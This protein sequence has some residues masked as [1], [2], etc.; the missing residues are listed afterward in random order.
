VL[1]AQHFRPLLHL[2]SLHKNE[3]LPQ[4]KDNHT[5]IIARCYINIYVCSSPLPSMTMFVPSFCLTSHVVSV[6][7][8]IQQLG[9]RC[10][11]VSNR[12]ASHCFRHFRITALIPDVSSPP[13]FS[14]RV[15]SVIHYPIASYSGRSRIALNGTE[16]N[17]FFGCWDITK[18]S[19]A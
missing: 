9:V 14:S 1:V 8:L 15:R 3:C 16:S 5:C 17:R 18:R 2:V 19:S 4:P 10:L 12:W 7:I 13:I 11:R 6:Y